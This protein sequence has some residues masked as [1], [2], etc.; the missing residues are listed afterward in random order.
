MTQLLVREIATQPSKA[1]SP[2]GC[3]GW[4]LQEIGVFP[5]WGSLRLESGITR[6]WGSLGQESRNLKSSWGPEGPNAGGGRDGDLGEQEC[7]CSRVSPGRDKLGGDGGDRTRT[8]PP[9][10]P[11][12]PL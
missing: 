6:G 11:P 4:A 10:T 5:G 9:P 1:V 8:L 12:F 3:W 7:V 2:W